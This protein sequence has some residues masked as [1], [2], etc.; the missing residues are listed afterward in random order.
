ML[1]LAPL[2]LGRTSCTFAAAAHLV[3]CSEGKT[4]ATSCATRLSHQPS[5][6]QSTLPKACQA[7]R[8][9]FPCVQ[10]VS[11][12]P[13][14]KLREVVAQEQCAQRTTGALQFP[15]YQY[16]RMEQQQTYFA[17]KRLSTNMGVTC[18]G[19]VCASPYLSHAIVASG[20]HKSLVPR[21]ALELLIHESVHELPSCFS[22][23]NTNCESMGELSD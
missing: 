9:V 21:V 5:K 8:P 23:T 2:P 18:Y 12:V 7:R 14:T 20:N 15:C 6:S 4:E 22:S 13:G 10:E 17:A 3:E 19:N 1:A 11:Q 16:P